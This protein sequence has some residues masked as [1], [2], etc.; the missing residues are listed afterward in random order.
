MRKA[1]EIRVIMM[2]FVLDGFYL[3]LWDKEIG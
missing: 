3:A 1:R 2:A